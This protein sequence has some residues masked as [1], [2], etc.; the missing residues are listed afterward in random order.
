MTHQLTRILP[1]QAILTQQRLL[2][3][4]ERE[5]VGET[6]PVPEVGEHRAA[7]ETSRSDRHDQGHQAQLWQQ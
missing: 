6:V 5:S 2:S 1:L 7:R 3:T 4:E